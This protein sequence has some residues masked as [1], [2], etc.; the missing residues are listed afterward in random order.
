M[1]LQALIP[2]VTAPLLTS[3]L[4]SG[5]D[6]ELPPPRSS[7]QKRVAI[8]GAGAGGSSAAYHLSQY[9]SLD[10]TP[11]SIDVFE[12][13]S[14]IGGRTTTVPAWNLATKPVELGG[15]IFVSVNQI[16]VEAAQRF[17]LSTSGLDSEDEDDGGVKPAGTPELGIWNG[18]EFVVTTNAEDGWWDKAK[19][20]WRYGLA[21]IKTNRLMKDTVGKFLRIYDEPLFPWESLSDVAEE[22]GLTTVT[23]H[24]GEQF[25]K[26]SGIGDKFAKEIIQAS[27]RVNYASHLN[28]IHGLE[29]M[30]CMATSGAK[31][32]KG[33]NWQIFAHMLNSSSSISTYLNTT[34]T[35]ITRDPSTQKF[36]LTTSSPSSSASSP[37]EEAQYD[38]IILATP[39]QF[40]SP[41]TFHP[42]PSHLPKPIPYVHLHV[43][44]FASPHR[45]S[46][47]RF[48]LPPDTPVPQF[49]LTT[50]P[51]DEKPP[52]PKN[53]Q[54]ESGAG[55]AG[56]P[57]F[58]SVSVVKTG[59]NPF[60][61]DR[62][63]EYIYKIFSPAPITAANLT[64]L[65]GHD[66]D[67]PALHDDEK[68]QEDG[69]VDIPDRSGA[70]SWLYRKAWRSYPYE[71]PRVT[72]EE[73][74]L[75]DGVYYTSGIESF[76]STMETSA[77]MGKNVARLVA[78]D[79][80][81]Q[82]GAQQQQQQQQESGESLVGSEEQWRFQ[83]ADGESEMQVP[84]E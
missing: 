44:L 24:T 36:T 83:G 57:G 73:I 2:L 80:L 30:V 66:V 28:L 13:S 76:I 45:L 61:E 48:N 27:T 1:H 43:T 51:D 75:D 14:Y 26:A 71:L 12:R 55:A 56:S 79:W 33:G 46:P 35:S 62:R 38:T 67:I 32:I 19:L 39:L 6:Q 3:A 37:E 16:L 18:R 65:L 29:T 17:D 11:F 8:I 31:A 59:R 81:A 60:A 15:S 34:V 40:S 9:A 50:L 22:V 21:P 20:L 54:G 23:S 64:E 52:S 78:N 82:K 10:G 72:F 63:S 42:S 41:L 25:L 49:V 68:E 5:H 58:F 4:R 47:T 70:V 7:A 74:R 53:P 84:L 77:L 69:E